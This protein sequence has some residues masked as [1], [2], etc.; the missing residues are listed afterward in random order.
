M[1]IILNAYDD[2]HAVKNLSYH[3]TTCL[4]N[5]DYDFIV[6]DHHH[7]LHKT[8][9][10]YGSLLNCSN[11]SFAQLKCHMF[12]CHRFECHRSCIRRKKSK[13]SPKIANVQNRFPRIFTNDYS[14]LMSSTGE[15]LINNN[16][17]QHW[18]VRARLSDS[19][20]ILSSRSP[21][22]FLIPKRDNVVVV[23]VFARHCHHPQVLRGWMPLRSDRL[24][25]RS[26]LQLP[27]T[28]TATPNT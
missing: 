15:K 2:H 21:Y 1:M 22:L 11:L 7:E 12:E 23:V 13:F 9:F 25:Q 4:P 27:A 14:L 19:R 8:Q 3:I 26:N 17:N 6:M 10:S 24:G 5:D 18:G 28:A 16:Y 20:G